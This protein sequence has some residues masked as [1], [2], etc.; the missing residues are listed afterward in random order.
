MIKSEPISNLSTDLSQRKILVNGPLVQE[1]RHFPKPGSDGTEVQIVRPELA[2]VVDDQF[3]LEFNCSNESKKLNEYL[4]VMV[5]YVNDRYALN[6]D[7]KIKF[8][9]ATVIAIYVSETGH[10]LY[11]YKSL[12]MT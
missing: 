4:A 3:C 11:C 6:K 5:N 1:P 7:P 2:I 8:Q 10:C 12:L 9:I